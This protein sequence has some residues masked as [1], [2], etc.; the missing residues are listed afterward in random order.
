[1]G[2]CD[3]QSHHGWLHNGSCGVLPVEPLLD[4]LLQ[5]VGA[6]Q[7]VAQGYPV[8]LH[9]V[10]ASKQFNLPSAGRKS[11]NDAVDFIR[12]VAG[13]THLQEQEQQSSLVEACV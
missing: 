5:N 10:H 6:V 3:V 8:R 1:M 2:S 7:L 4:I 11:L 9:I 13:G 12:L